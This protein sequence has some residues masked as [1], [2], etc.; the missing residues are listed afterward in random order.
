MA[1]N[2]LLR[3]VNEECPFSSVPMQ[4]D[5][6]EASAM[7]GLQ[8]LRSII[9]ASS[10]SRLILPKCFGPNSRLI[11]DHKST[12][13]SIVVKGLVF[14]RDS[15][16]LGSP[17]LFPLFCHVPLASFVNVLH[18]GAC[19]SRDSVHEPR[20]LGAKERNMAWVV[21]N[22]KPLQVKLWASNVCAKR[23]FGTRFDL[24][25]KRMPRP[26]AIAASLYLSITNNSSP[27]YLDMRRCYMYLPALLPKGTDGLILRLVAESISDLRAH[28]KKE[29]CGTTSLHFVD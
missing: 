27:V 14:S 17:Y 12:P 4:P 21:S 29:T 19:S 16:I 8:S 5:H 3:I 22:R 13:S 10:F 23:N 6:H 18:M 11:N 15:T 26:C 24:Q 2:L 7:L 1:D 9:L 28:Y 25:P 20:Q